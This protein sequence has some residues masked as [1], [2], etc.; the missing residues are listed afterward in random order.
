MAG[1][2]RLFNVDIYYTLS[3][4][5]FVCL[6]TILIVCQLQLKFPSALSCFEKIRESAGD[7]KIVLF[8]DYDGTLSPIV[9]DPD[10]AFM[11]ADVS[12]LII[13]CANRFA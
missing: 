11:S 5:F 2:L 10:R 12:G 13:L 1:L 8:L 3:F 7:K 4:D 9:D 6:F